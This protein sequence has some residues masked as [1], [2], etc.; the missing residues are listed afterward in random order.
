MVECPQCQARLRIPSEKRGAKIRCPK[1]QHGFVAGADETP[2][3]NERPEKDV[4]S[5]SRNKSGPKSKSPK[6]KSKKSSGPPLGLIAGG[7]ALTVALAVVAFALLRSEG[8]ERPAE[9]APA[10]PA[11][12]AAGQAATEPEAVPVA[13]VDA[14]TAPATPLPSIQSQLPEM[15]DGSGQLPRALVE[16]PD[17]LVEDV[18]F[19]V[20]PFWVKLPPGQNAAQLYLDALYEFSP[21]MEVCF[22]ENTRAQ[23]TAPIRQRY[24]RSQ[25]MQMARSE[26]N[27]D[28]TERDA[29]LAEYEEAFRKLRAAQAPADCVFDY[30]IDTPAMM[31][32]FHAAR[33]VI[34]L[35]GFAVERDLERQDFGHALQMIEISLRLSRDLRVRAPSLAQ[36]IAQALDAVIEQNM[37]VPLLRSPQITAEHCNQLLT[38]STTHEQRLRT[39]DPWLTAQRANYIRFRL[40]INDIQQGTGEF[41]TERI[42]NA[43]GVPNETRMMA[44][45]NAVYDAHDVFSADTPMRIAR[46]ATMLSVFQQMLKTDDFDYDAEIAFLKEQF[47]INAQS[48]SQSYSERMASREQISFFMG[49]LELERFMKSQ[50]RGM[51]QEQQVAS[52]EKAIAEGTVKGPFLLLVPGMIN[53]EWD[54]MASSNGVDSDITGKTRLQGI[55]ALTAVRRWY[56]IHAEPPADLASVCRDA[57]LT[58]LPHDFFGA[59]PLK[60]R[61]IAVDTPLKSAHQAD[62]K[63]LANEVI[64]YSVGKNGVDDQGE[65]EDSFNQTGDL[66]FRLATP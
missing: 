5:S 16:L 14:T 2:S 18:P 65:I 54:M 66:L 43:F 45:L 28:L 47:R 9:V 10:N 23:R 64:I 8:D 41:A 32:L 26:T 7:G 21:L 48:A 59:G 1:C 11:I 25:T 61:V 3:D 31:P 27:K 15:R 46:I 52:I 56:A 24:D 38:L 50:P 4:R 58:E 60:L 51:N 33:E 57:G 22:S 53:S 55:I 39:I 19:D 13:R 36:W 12:P 37:I 35:A 6:K 29:V 30:G 49:N 42:R 62:A 40:L 63:L 34:R 20:K 44:V 17:W